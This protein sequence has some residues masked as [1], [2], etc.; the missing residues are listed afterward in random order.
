MVVRPQAREAVVL[1]S[2]P[3]SS[4]RIH[5][6]RTQNGSQFRKPA[7]L[8]IQGLMEC[9]STHPQTTSRFSALQFIPLGVRGLRNERK[10][11]SR[12]WHL[13]VGL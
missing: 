8:T 9:F 7:Y 11:C 3:D 2:R 4:P 10:E 1:A 6:W 12:N 13:S 5:L